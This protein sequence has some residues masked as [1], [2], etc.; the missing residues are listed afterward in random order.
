MDGYCW[1]ELSHCI[2]SLESLP[3]LIIGLSTIAVESAISEGK[4]ERKHH[5]IG[6][7]PVRSAEPEY[8]CRYF[9]KPILFMTLPDS[10]RGSLLPRLTHSS[11]PFGPAAPAQGPAA[12]IKV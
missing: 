11:I 1:N 7:G 10:F 8:A 5:R 6:N 3:T 4:S 12:R 2:L 9:C